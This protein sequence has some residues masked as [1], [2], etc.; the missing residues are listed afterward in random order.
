MHATIARCC[1]GL[2]ELETIQNVDRLKK[3]LKVCCQLIDTFLDVGK[4]ENDFR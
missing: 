1:L 2:S 3:D 4:M